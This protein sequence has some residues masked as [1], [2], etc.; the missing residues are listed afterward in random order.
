M[1]AN[2]KKLSHH[3]TGEVVSGQG[4][5]IT[6]NI[7][8]NIITEL[9]T[10]EYISLEKVEDIYTDLHRTPDDILEFIVENEK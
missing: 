7:F 4:L 1:T 5:V 6:S 3:I 10:G 9:H 2:Y 8:T